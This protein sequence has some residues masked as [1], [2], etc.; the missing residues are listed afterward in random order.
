[1]VSV[2]NKSLWSK[3]RHRPVSPSPSE[4]KISGWWFFE[5]GAF[6]KTSKAYETIIGSQA[7]DRSYLVGLRMSV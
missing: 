4:K 2:S 1:M 5:V 3:M 7:Y 6:V